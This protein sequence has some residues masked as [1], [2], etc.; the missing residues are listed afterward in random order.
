MQVDVTTRVAKVRVLK[1]EFRVLKL[2]TRV[3]ILDTRFNGTLSVDIG[4]YNEE[5]SVNAVL[6]QLRHFC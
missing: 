2:E 4:P 3:L 1:I 5:S 6:D